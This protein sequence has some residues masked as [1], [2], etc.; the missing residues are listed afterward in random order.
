MEILEAF[1]LTGCANSAAALCGVDP[2]TVRRYVAARNE[3]RSVTGVTH[4]DRLY[5]PYLPHIEEWVENSQGKIWADKVH[6]KLVPLGYPGA[7]RSTSRAVAQVKAAWKL[8]HQRHYRPWLTEPGKWLQ[9]DWGEGPKVP[10]P[11]G[12]LRRTFLF[13]AWLAWSR[14]RVVIPV[15]DLTLPGL[16]ACLDETLR[17]VG[18]VPTYVLTDNPKTVTIEHIAGIPIRNPG[19]VKV[20]RHYGTQVYT[21][22]VFDPESKGGSEATVRIA[23]ADL[24]PKD[25][26]LLAEYE[27]F[28]ELEHACVAFCDKVNNRKH[29]ETNRV[30]SEALLTERERLHTLPVEPHTIALGE[31]RKVNKDQTVWVENCRYSTPPGLTGCEVWVQTHG[32]DVVF[33]T[34]LESLPVK[35]DW[36]AGR[37]GLVEVARHRKST[38]GNPSIDLS[39]YPGHPQDESGDPKPLKPEARSKAESQFLAIGDGASDWLV[40]A[41]LVGVSRVQAKMASAV[42]LAALVGADRVNEAL[43]AAA[44]AGR[45]DE[46]DLHSICDHLASEEPY[47][48]VVIADEAFS[49][50]TGTNSWHGFTTVQEM[51]A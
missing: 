44:V 36:A 6:E 18:G 46:G 13:C 1:D 4:R 39:H 15:W 19:I 8:T 5:D 34:N 21:C 32:D 41:G 10:G 9:F 51:A 33:V 12:V 38:P 50:Q 28:A 31:T 22:V 17:T 30:P 25:T 3:G 26:N 37:S 42:E 49:A 14:F 23:K 2:K 40:E 16:A 24:V 47:P 29:R 45:F 35:P 48:S 27:S 43:V 20:G 11:D 7:Q